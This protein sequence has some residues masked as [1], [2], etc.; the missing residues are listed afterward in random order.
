MK[1]KNLEIPHPKMHERY[2]VL[3]PLYELNKLLIHPVLKKSIKELL[4][5][6][7]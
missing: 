5:D 6:L 4:E 3:K 2:F 7:S 1:T